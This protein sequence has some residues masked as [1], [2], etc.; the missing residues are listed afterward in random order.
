MVSAWYLEYQKPKT[1][2]TLLSWIFHL[3]FN[4]NKMW[5]NHKGNLGASP[6][7]LFDLRLPS[8]LKCFPE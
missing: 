1:A 8:I 6:P 3:F 2:L 4:I 7:V 5:S